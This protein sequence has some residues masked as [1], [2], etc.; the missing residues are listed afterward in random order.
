MRAARD[1]TAHRGVPQEAPESPSVFT[2]PV[3][4]F[5]GSMIS[6]WSAQGLGWSFDHL[7]MTCFAYADDVLLFADSLENL[8]R[9]FNTCCASFDRAGLVVGAE[10][11]HWRSAV[12]LN[13]VTMR[14]GEQDVLWER[15]LT[16]V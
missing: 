8:T 5:L 6:K 10:K 16:F 11:T 2:M 4:V 14:A 12:M 3:D 1:V 15:S 7:L 13:G 9:M